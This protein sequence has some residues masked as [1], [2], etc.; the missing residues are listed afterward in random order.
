MKMSKK[1]A[2][3]IKN[4]LDKLNAICDASKG[5]K[6]SCA[7]FHNVGDE[8]TKQEIAIGIRIYLQTWVIPEMEAVLKESN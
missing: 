7:V 2:N 8:K 3:R 5:I 1:N 4:A 6:S